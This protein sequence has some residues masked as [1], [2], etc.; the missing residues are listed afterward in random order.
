MCVKIYILL[1]RYASETFSIAA[2]LCLQTQIVTE[3]AKHLILTI[4]STLVCCFK[5]LLVSLISQ[6]FFLPSFP[7]WCLYEAGHFVSS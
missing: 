7:R 1:L 6:E 2:L 5:T 4:K 3:N